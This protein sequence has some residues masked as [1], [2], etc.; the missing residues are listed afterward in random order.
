MCVSCLLLI[1]IVTMHGL[2]MKF[3]SLPYSQQPATCPY[4]EADK[5][6]PNPLIPHSVS[7]RCIDFNQ[8]DQNS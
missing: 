1:L 7:I 6:I 4:P 3:S 8:N 5:F 2:T